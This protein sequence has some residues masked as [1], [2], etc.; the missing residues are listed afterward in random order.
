M[1]K[2]F[3]TYYLVVLLCA[4]AAAV[5]IKIQK[6]E[7]AVC[8]RIHL[9][10]QQPSVHLLSIRNSILKTLR[11]RRTSFC[12]LFVV[13]AILFSVFAWFALLCG[14]NFRFASERQNVYLLMIW[15]CR[16]KK[17]TTT[18]SNG[19]IRRGSAVG[20]AS[21]SLQNEPKKH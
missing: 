8:V 5:Q 21:H 6:P 7:Q 14:W 3:Y 11:I 1:R 19:Q 15:F 18:N 13:F 4:V 9:N 16:N 12:V 2:N 17:K 20:N 10:I